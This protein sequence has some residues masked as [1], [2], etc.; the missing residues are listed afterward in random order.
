MSS[1]HSDR[2]ICVQ[3]ASVDCFMNLRQGNGRYIQFCNVSNVYLVCVFVFLPQE[4]TCIQEQ[5]SK[6]RTA[7]YA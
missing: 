6:A 7:T 4:R 3:K 5:L 1:I 2:Y